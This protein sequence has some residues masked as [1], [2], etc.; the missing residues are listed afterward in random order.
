MLCDSIHFSLCSVLMWNL[1]EVLELRQ[2]HFDSEDHKLP[3]KQQRAVVLEVD[4]QPMIR[5]HHTPAEGSARDVAVAI[6]DHIFG[7]PEK[8]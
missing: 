6:I 3:V 2:P 1:G 7:T 5:M 4:W 8:N